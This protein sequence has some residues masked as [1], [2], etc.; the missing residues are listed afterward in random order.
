M[1]APRITVP[2]TDGFDV[3]CPNCGGEVRHEVERLSGYGQ[4]I[5]QCV[6]VLKCG[7]WRTL[8]KIRRPA[9]VRAPR[10]AERV[11][12]VRSSRSS[13]PRRSTREHL[14]RILQL[15]PARGGLGVTVEEVAPRVGLTRAR[16]KQLLDLLWDEGTVTREYRRTGRGGR[17]PY[18]YWKAA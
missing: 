10:G 2:T 7:Y 1:R 17:Q 13:G 9:H 4:T 15:A 14:D 16:T 5:E 18:Q 8:E 3:T 6:N 11:K 12:V